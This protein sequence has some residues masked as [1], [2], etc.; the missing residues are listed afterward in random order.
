MSILIKGGWFC[1]GNWLFFLRFIDCVRLRLFVGFLF[2]AFL[3]NPFSSVWELELGIYCILEFEPRIFCAIY[4]VWDWKL[5]LCMVQCFE[6]CNTWADDL[7]T[8]FDCTFATWARLRWGF[9]HLGAMWLVICNQGSFGLDSAL[10]S[11]LRCCMLYKDIFIIQSYAV[12]I[13]VQAYHKLMKRAV[14]PALLANCEA[15]KL[16]TTPP[17]MPPA[18]DPH[19]APD[20]KLDLNQQRLHLFKDE[21]P[22]FGPSD[23]VT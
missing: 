23:F 19:A 8:V 21:L 5:F 17:A 13:P 3:Y 12:Y 18:T 6:F 15:A 7:F 20:P 11:G 14:F 9:Q 10:V 2:C 16:A 1:L 22:R 4:R